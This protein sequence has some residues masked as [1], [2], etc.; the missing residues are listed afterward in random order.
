M[1]SG[2]GKSSAWEQLPPGGQGDS[3]PRTASSTVR[4]SGPDATRR[5]MSSIASATAAARSRAR[6]VACG[7]HAG[8]PDAEPPEIVCAMAATLAVNR[9]SCGGRA[10]VWRCGPGPGGGYRGAT[11]RRGEHGRGSTMAN[12]PLDGVRIIELQGI[13]PGPFCGMM[14]A[15][16]GADVIRIDRAANVPAEPTRPRRR[17]TCWPAAAARS[18]ST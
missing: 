7:P 18:A 13:G 15:D 9:G 14:L 2:A 11:C 3:R 16:M 4:S 6:S 12:G 10:E 17:S 8:D 5:R 1:A